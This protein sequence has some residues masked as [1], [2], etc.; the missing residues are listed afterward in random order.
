MNLKY[1]ILIATVFMSC[2]SPKEEPQEISEEAP[3]SPENKEFCYAYRAGDEMRIMQYSIESD[4]VLG[5]LQNYFPGRD[6][7]NGS[8]SGNLDGDTLFI[9]FL[10]QHKQKDTMRQ[11][12]FLRQG[13]H[14]LEGS[15]TLMENPFGDMVFDRGLL[16]FSDEK[17]LNLVTCKDNKTLSADYEI[18]WSVLKGDYTDL[19]RFGKV[20]KGELDNA[21]LIMSEDSMFGE[22]ILP[23]NAGA[24]ILNKKNMNGTSVF[25]NGPYVLN[26]DGNVQLTKSGQVL[27][28]E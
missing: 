8:I 24:L 10:Y 25:S 21:Y 6:M 7:T 22:V 19:R 20:L 28:Q 11:L 17:K 13:D 27:Y 5:F 3:S 26:L 15:G 14:L 9:R 16:Q 18:V 4:E 23:Q 1:L 2:M 12:A